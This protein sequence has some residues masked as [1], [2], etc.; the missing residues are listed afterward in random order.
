MAWQVTPI[1][2]IY[3]FAAAV[4]GMTTVYVWQR[5]SDT[6][7]GGYLAALM[8][9]VAWWSLCDGLGS[10][11]VDLRLRIV[12]SQ[13]SHVAIQLI[14]VFLLVFIA[15]YTRQDRWLST[16]RLMLL[17]VM[18]TLTLI[19]V[20][21][22]DW[23][24]LIWP[25]VHLMLYPIGLVTIFT[26][27]VWFGVMVA[28][29]YML[30]AAALVL[31][32]RAAVLHPAL[33]R[34]R[35]MVILPAMLI[36]WLG[37]ILYIFNL[38]PLQ[39]LDWTS[40]SFVATGLLMTWAVFHLGLLELVPVARNV[41]FANMTDGLLVLDP[42]WRIVD[43][44][45]AVTQMLGKTLRIWDT[46]AQLPG[47]DKETI[48][49][50]RTQGAAQFVLPG[51][52]GKRFVHMRNTALAD[53]QGR[54][55]GFLIVLH[56]ISEM[57]RYEMQLCA[58]EQAARKAKEI[59]ESATQA[60]TEFLANMSHE[61]RT[62]MNAIV[63]MTSLL[64]DTEMTAQ[65][66]EYVETVRSSSDS[67]LM[68]VNDILDFS[69]IEA[70]KLELELQPFDLL[71]CLE[72]AL[73]LVAI[74][75]AH[76]G[77]E[78]IYDVGD[79]APRMVRGDVTRLRQVVVNLL[80]NAVKFTDAGEVTLAVTALDLVAPDAPLADLQAS[81]NFSVQVQIAVRD[82]GIGIP[83]ARI[84]HLFRS[85]TQV[86]AST[87]RRFGGTGLG[88]AI[89][90]RLVQMMGGSIEA[91]SNG[92]AGQGSVF[93]VRLPMEVVIERAGDDVGGQA[94]VLQ[95]KA[96]LVVDDNAASRKILHH[97]L[98]SWGMQVDLASCS[99]EAL[100]LLLAGRRFDLAILDGVMPDMDGFALARA[101]REHFSAGQMALVMLT[102]LDQQTEKMAAMSAAYLRKPVKPAQLQE[103]LRRQLAPQ[104]L[105][106]KP[107]RTER[108]DSTLGE[109]HP[110]RIL[111]AEDNRVNQ[112]V[113][114]GLPCRRAMAIAPTRQAMGWRYWRP[115]TGSHTTWC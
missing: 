83:S 28:Y 85:F 53:K 115:C 60:K 74:Q 112:K 73:D 89:S 32:L 24:K 18:P 50:V 61:I 80:S 90:R 69:K 105:S 39:G 79:G 51:G 63:G 2:L 43:M 107:A 56:D 47:L 78:L 37:N 81:G 75:A 15:I 98:R 76:K 113:M 17:F 21:T 101:I 14:P 96:V 1:A 45:P 93:R 5:R 108:W 87:T 11:F 35:A 46:F 36:P 26:H 42:Q 103:T 64:L 29:A 27:G 88:L 100:A 58:S 8:L 92:V 48:E 97:Q 66:A 44:N 67:L 86:D 111:M 71:A 34:G 30:L 95:G 23:H 41:L 77:L 52:E 57:K 99:A 94:G 104:L 70:G 6:L 22:N 12:L 102:S 16:H 110:L 84:E 25:S 38:L 68:I 9:G 109:R 49:A 91:E 33:Y 55:N 31:Q 65:Q 10:F 19:L 4:A 82:T 62:P 59:A 20:F 13:L 40:I 3:L 54:V 106:E 7:G 114:H 72:S